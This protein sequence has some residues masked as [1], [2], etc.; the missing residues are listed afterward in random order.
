M[1]D[2]LT[3]GRRGRKK[4]EQRWK[5]RNSDYAKAELKKLR[6]TRERKKARGRSTCSRISQFVKDQYTEIDKVPTWN[7]IVKGVSISRRTVAYDMST[8]KELR[9]FRRFRWSIP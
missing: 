9:R 1:R 7:V 4:A 2:R 6:K 3:M 5:D 8:L